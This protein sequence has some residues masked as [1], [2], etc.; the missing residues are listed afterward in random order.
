MVEIT[1][2]I[3]EY[4]KD[5][6]TDA[7]E[8]LYVDALREV[9]IRRVGAMQNHLEDIRRKIGAYEVRYRQSFEQFA[10]NVPNTVEGHDDWIEWS[11]L[12]KLLKELASRLDTLKLVAGQ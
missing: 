1:I 8:T 7:G 12:A 6:V 4:I 10:E 5:V 9:A 3:P 11:Y 2:K